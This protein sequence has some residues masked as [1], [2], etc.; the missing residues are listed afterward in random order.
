M[1]SFSSIAIGKYRSLRWCPCTSTWSSHAT[2]ARL[3]SNQASSEAK[4]TINRCSTFIVMVVF[5][6]MHCSL[7]PTNLFITHYYLALGYL[8][9]RR[10]TI[11]LQELS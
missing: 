5:F 2:L 1:F 6:P 8:L 3:Y 4:I 11:K 9:A 7:P 10:L